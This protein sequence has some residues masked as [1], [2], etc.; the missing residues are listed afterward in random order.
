MGEIEELTKRIVEFREKRDWKKFHSFKDLAMSI[1]V[2]AAELLEIFLWKRGNELEN[3]VKK[4][5]KEIKEELA[6]IF[7]GAFLLAHDLGYDVYKIVKDKIE[8]NEKKYP[9]EKFKGIS[10]K[11]NE[12]R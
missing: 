10:A 2:E 11:Y 5:E 9:V 4:K 6:D 8:K 12:V 1:S 3:V 7:T